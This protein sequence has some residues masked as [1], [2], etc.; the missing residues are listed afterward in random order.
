LFRGAPPAAEPDSLGSGESALFCI[1]AH[2][3]GL[4]L[5]A[6]ITS[7]GGHF[8]REARTVP[9]Y[10]LFGLGNRPGR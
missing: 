9:A 8:V 3:G 6:Q 10:R 4:P 1:G 5:N 2:T 7:L